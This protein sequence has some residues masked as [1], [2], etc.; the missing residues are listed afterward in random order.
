MYLQLLFLVKSIALVTCAMEG[1]VLGGKKTKI[2]AYPHSILLS[3]TCETTY[4]CGGSILNQNLVL[5]AAHCL[6][7]CGKNTD[8]QVLIKSGHENT[9]NMNSTKMR[10]FVMHEKYDEFK[11]VNDICLVMSERPLRLGDLVK[12]VILLPSPK[13]S[14]KLAYIAGWG[15]MNVSSP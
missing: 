11:M 1:F 12:R 7:D 13:F 10:A 5:T 8:D 9:S 15:V 14:V 3:I 6:E 4:I 2:A